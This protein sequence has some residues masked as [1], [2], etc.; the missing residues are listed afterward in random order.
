MQ[1]PIPLQGLFPRTPH[2]VSFG[3][4]PPPM[5]RGET[6]TH[7]PGC[8]LWLLSIWSQMPCVGQGQ[9]LSSSETGTLITAVLPYRIVMR[10]KSD[11]TCKSCGQCLARAKCPV[12]ALGSRCLCRW[13]GSIK[14]GSEAGWWGGLQTLLVPSSVNVLNIFWA[15]S[16]FCGTCR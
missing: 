10:V 16:S 9:V 5:V 13:N 1:P 11:N 3:S 8:L 7:Q 2:T 14:A 15:W 6:S 4:W 12:A